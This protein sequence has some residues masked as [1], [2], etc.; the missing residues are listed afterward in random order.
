[1]QKP[2]IASRP[3]RAPC[4]TSASSAAPVSCIAASSSMSFTRAI[5]ALAIGI[6]EHLAVVEIRR[7]GDVAGAREA[8]AHALDVG[9][10]A[11]RLHH[12]HDPDAGDAAGLGEVRGGPGASVR[13][14]VVSAGA[15]I[16]APSGGGRS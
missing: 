4:A 10:Q 14:S 9:V 16:G 1:M 11:E 6:L 7:D 12:D 3:S 2:M 15:A 13:N 5:G 8:F